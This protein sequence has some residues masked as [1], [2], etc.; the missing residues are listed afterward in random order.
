MPTLKQRA[1]AK[2][3]VE[4]AA[5]DKP[6]TA[7]ELLEIAG[8]DKT[9]ALSSP[10]RTIEQVGVQQALEEFGF[11]EDNAKS[12]VGSILLDT[13]VDA[14]ARLKAAD[15]VFKVKGSYAPEKTVS[16]QVKT[17]MNPHDEKVKAITDR[18]EQELLTTIMNGDRLDT[19]R[20]NAS[21]MEE[22]EK[23]AE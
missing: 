5:A 16:L 15:M 22:T 7:G 3:I 11:T 10:G 18:Y 14:N 19:E 1:L 8:Y 2:A 6:K 9:T 17:T 20:T 21:I 4:N 23:R 12:V 13:A